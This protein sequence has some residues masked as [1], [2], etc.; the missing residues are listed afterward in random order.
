MNQYTTFIFK[1][2]VFDQESKRL[3]LFYSFDDTLNFKESFVFDFPF[4]N[5]DHQVLDQAL[6]NL[7]IMAG[8]SYF[9]AYPVDRILILKKGLTRKEADFFET[10]Y[11]R[12]L[13]EYFYVNG[14]DPNRPISFDGELEE[15][16]ALNYSG[17][18]L[19]IG[20]GGGKDSLVVVE[21]LKESGN[22]IKTWSLGHQELLLPLVNQ[23]G[24][25]HCFVQRTIDP[26]LIELNSKGALNGHIPISA[27]FS[28]V[29]IIVAIL[30]GYSDVV[31]G[32]EASASES[33]L[34]YRGVLINHQYSKSIQYEKDFGEL[35]RINFGSRLKYYSFLRPLSE[36]RIGEI[37][38]K[39]YFD[40]Y[41]DLFSSCNRSYIHG[42]NHLYWCGECS[43]CAFMFLIL[44]P[45]IDE[46][47]LVSLWKGKNLLKDQTLIATY[48][49]L[50]GI[51]GH[52]PLDCVGEIREARFAMNLAF[53]KYPDLK[54]IYKFDLD[55]S[56]DYRNI[57]PDL[58]P[59][60]IHQ[61]FLDYLSR[62]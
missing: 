23:V 37:F 19:M 59:E 21:A 8:V 56:Y 9:K 26:L 38:A 60:N 4:S 49:E 33:N 36:L 50:L 12:G 29:G 48:K 30:N 11:Q 3:D 52:K 28:F 39:N 34:E 45:F 41:K 32:N 22:K 55:P 44:S 1:D 54:N 43:K 58:M 13:G 40:K 61:F 17:D 47:K 24:L 16:P 7:F 51:S 10:T 35:L 18:G 27:I 2:Y 57:G 15:K 5:Y 20:L 46:H 31:V 25:E 6:F 14:L 53:E 62:V 42:N